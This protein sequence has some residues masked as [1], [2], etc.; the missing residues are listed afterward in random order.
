MADSLNVVTPPAPD[1]ST[2]PAVQT[3]ITDA[4]TGAKSIVTDIEDKNV[5]GLVAS[6]FGTGTSLVAAAPAAIAEVKAGYKTTEFWGVV[7]AGL[8]ASLSTE[9]WL[10]KVVAGAIAVLYA[11]TRAFT[12]TGA[13]NAAANAAAWINPAKQ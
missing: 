9:G 8:N 6:A 3:V 5:S 12:K 4:V 10:P 7:A 13:K 1:P 2:D 11:I